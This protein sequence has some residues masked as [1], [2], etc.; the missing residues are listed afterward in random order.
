M[1]IIRRYTEN[2]RL[3]QLH[4]KSIDDQ[5]DHFP[6]I[7]EPEAV[8]I[9]H[10]DY[11]NQE[12]GDGESCALRK[13]FLIT[14][15]GFMGRGPKLVQPGDIAVVFLGAKVP[16]ILRKLGAEYIILGEC[17]KSCVGVL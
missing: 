6:D 11:A 2:I 8:H 9:L 13:R 16:F 15:K 10:R 7:P 17:C 4:L 3:R 14:S 5:Q 1:G 12:M